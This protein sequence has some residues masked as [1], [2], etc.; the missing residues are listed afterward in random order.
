MLSW[1]KVAKARRRGCSSE[2]W[3]SSSFAKISPRC[4]KVW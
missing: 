2:A 1:K 3:R 4:V